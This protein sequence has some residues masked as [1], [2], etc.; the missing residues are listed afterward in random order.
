MDLERIWRG[1]FL[2]WNNFRE[3]KMRWKFFKQMKEF[4][5]LIK[6]GLGSLQLLLAQRYLTSE[7]WQ[8]SL[9]VTYV[10]KWNWDT[11]HKNWNTKTNERRMIIPCVSLSFHFL[12]YPIDFR[13]STQLI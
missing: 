3:D 11:K 4:Y 9:Q 10:K 7:Y 12:W 1:F 5:Q 6:N 13:F 2:F 8:W